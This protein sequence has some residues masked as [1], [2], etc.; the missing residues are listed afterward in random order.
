MSQKI[1]SS[2]VKGFIYILKTV[3]SW[4]LF[5]SK[6]KIYMLQAKRVIGHFMECLRISVIF[7]NDWPNR[8]FHEMANICRYFMKSLTNFYANCLKLILTKLC[9]LITWNMCIRTLMLHNKTYQLLKLF[10]E[11]KQ[12]VIIKW[13]YNHIDSNCLSIFEDCANVTMHTFNYALLILTY[14]ICFKTVSSLIINTT[15]CNVV[16]SCAI[17]SID[18]SKK[19]TG[20]LF[21]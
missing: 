1:I 6:L 18:F 10:L 14:T 11:R 15:H 17:V 19:P 12:R 21:L 5:A 7:G 9:A 13:Y 3:T 4:N 8:V 20:V 2:E 16:V